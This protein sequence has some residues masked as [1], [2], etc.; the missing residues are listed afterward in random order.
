MAQRSHPYGLEEWVAIRK[1]FDCFLSLG[2]IKVI[3]FKLSKMAMREVKK[4]AGNIKKGY[5]HQVDFI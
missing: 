4:K 1:C 5:C 3:C 2:M